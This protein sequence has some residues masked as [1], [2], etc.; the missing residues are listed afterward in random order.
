MSA[1]SSRKRG[2]RGPVPTTASST[3]HAAAQPSRSEERNA[4]VRA[5]LTALAPG[6][7]P[8]P[9]KVAVAVALLIAVADILQVALGSTVKFGGTQGVA[10]VAL[11]SA[12]MLI[13]AIGMWRLRYW[14]VLGFMALLALVVI[15]FTL[16]LVSSTDALRAVIAVAIIA[17]GGYLFFKLVR[18]VSRLQ[19][20]TPGPRR[21]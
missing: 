14:A 1:R 9:L 10:G 19:M 15:A 3:P 12:I 16:V 18:V 17:G 5:T 13:C 2:R 11:F 7:R 4:A 6:E 8:W 20:P 21:D